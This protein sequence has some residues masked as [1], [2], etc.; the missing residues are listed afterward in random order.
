[1]LAWIITI[2]MVTVPMVVAL[3]TLAYKIVTLK[4]RKEIRATGLKISWWKC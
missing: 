4:H 1:M 2:L 3:D